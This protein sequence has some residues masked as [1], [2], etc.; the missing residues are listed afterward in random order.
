MWVLLHAVGAQADA[1]VR[2][3]HFGSMARGVSLDS[4]VLLSPDLAGVLR[5]AKCW[6]HLSIGL[7]IRS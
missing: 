4:A 2:T 6:H 3:K 5:A 1:L 7:H